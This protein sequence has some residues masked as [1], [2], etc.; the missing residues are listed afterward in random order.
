M[1][2]A[3]LWSS[4]GC[5]ILIP[6]SHSL[7]RSRIRTHMHPSRLARSPSVG[8]AAAAG[9]AVNS[10]SPPRSAPAPC[11]AAFAFINNYNV[12]AC[13]TRR[14]ANA[15]LLRLAPGSH[16]ERDRVGVGMV[17]WLHGV[18]LINRSS[19][20]RGHGMHTHN[21]FNMQFALRYVRGY[22][23][24]P[25]PRPAPLPQPLL[26]LTP[27][28]KMAQNARAECASGGKSTHATAS[29]RR[30]PRPAAADGRVFSV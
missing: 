2:A 12:C 16:L 27:F 8:S 13:R 10:C 7:A 22:P 21:Y 25:S 18:A 4:S 23:P 26:A 11:G 28:G 29:T 24:S 6:V 9:H 3:A 15:V 30:Q 20:R 14:A 19:F 17:V 5:H 1:S